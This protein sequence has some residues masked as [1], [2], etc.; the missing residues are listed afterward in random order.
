[1]KELNLQF[2]KA[3][4]RLL[5]YLSKV[6]QERLKEYIYISL[7]LFTVSFFILFA[8]SPTLN[9]VANLNKQYDDNKLIYDALK[10]KRKDLASLD[11]QY[12]A[13]KSDIDFV[14]SAIPKSTKIP[15]LTRQ[16]ENIAA[17]N[18]L[19]ITKLAFGTIEIYPNVKTTPI[20]SFSFTVSVAGSRENANKFISD[21][22]NFDRIVG[23]DSIQTGT[24]QDKQYQLSFTG[25]AYFIND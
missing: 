1:M 23:I 18:D 13:L 24:N 10:Q 16:V 2:K 15:K 3:Y 6:D 17:S 7:T 11:T 12:E 9:T 5:D 14:Y 20:Y 4:K 8:I 22:I 21:L 19:K 25:K